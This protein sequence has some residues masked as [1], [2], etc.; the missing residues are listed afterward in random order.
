MEL[1]IVISV[2]VVFAVSAVTWT[3][4]HFSKKIHRIDSQTSEFRKMLLETEQRLGELEEEIHEVR[5]G[6]MGMG[7]R[8]KEISA[9]IDVVKSK[10]EDLQQL[11]PEV[12]LY[13]HAAKLVSS[14][15][16]VEEIMRE[17]ELPRGEAE[18]LLSFHK[19][20]QD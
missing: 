9:I 20:N 18:M 12:R 5:T 13:S 4:Y 6:S 1:V 10:Q 3:F 17:C 11:D 15:A 16:T 19:K 14:G 7:T 2:V 8:L